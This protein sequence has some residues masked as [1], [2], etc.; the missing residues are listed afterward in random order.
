MLC[1]LNQHFHSYFDV[2]IDTSRGGIIFNT[3]MLL[4]QDMTL[5]TVKKNDPHARVIMSKDSFNEKTCH[6]LPI[7]G[8][9]K[10]IISILLVPGS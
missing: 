4:C 9:V 3:F 2:D 5:D 1:P 6:Y 7:L 10:A 8:V